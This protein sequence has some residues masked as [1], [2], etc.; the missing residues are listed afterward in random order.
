MYIFGILGVTCHELW[1]GQHGSRTGFG[2]IWS[3]FGGHKAENVTFFSQKPFVAKVIG[4]GLG[5][6][7]ACFGSANR[8]S[9]VHLIKPGYQIAWKMMDDRDSKQAKT[10]S[11]MTLFK[12]DWG[13]TGRIVGV[14]GDCGKACRKLIGPYKVLKYRVTL[15]FG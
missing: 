9:G 13:A 8:H 10:G 2:R 12:T 7:C 15:G 6:V 3:D 1:P 11:K 14:F 4:N 5:M